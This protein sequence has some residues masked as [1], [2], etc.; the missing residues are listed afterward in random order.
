[1]DVNA[2]LSSILYYSQSILMLLFVITA[3]IMFYL[4]SVVQKMK[5]QA[6]NFSTEIKQIDLDVNR[7]FRN[8][9]MFMERFG[10]KY[11]SCLPHTSIQRI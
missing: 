8:H 5:E 1:M 3:E 6:R 7:T 11:V 9:V 4:F 2:A 10:V